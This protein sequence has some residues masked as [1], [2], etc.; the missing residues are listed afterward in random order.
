MTIFDIYENTEDDTARFQLGTYGNKPLIVFGANPSTATS[1]KSDRTITKINNTAQR[2]NFDGWTM[3]NLYP[4][5]ATNPESLPVNFNADFFSINLLNIEQVLRQ[6]ESPIILAAWGVVITVRPYLKNCLHDIL[7]ITQKYSCTWLC[8]GETKDG[9][10]RHPSR[11][12][13]P[14]EL[15]PFNIN[16]YISK[17]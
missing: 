15:K 5:R 16:E 14:K 1:E 8:L 13:Y 2:F 6:I 17:L 11:G 7:S 4:L 9:H 10:P 3:L 12:S